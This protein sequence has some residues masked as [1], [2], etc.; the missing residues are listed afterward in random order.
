MLDTQV[1]HQTMQNNQHQTLKFLHKENMSK[2]DF[3]FRTTEG[4]KFGRKQPNIYK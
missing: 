1:Q 4:D 2:I 3:I